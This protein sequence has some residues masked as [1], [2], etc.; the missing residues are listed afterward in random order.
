MI[1]RM[2]KNYELDLNKTLPYFL[3]HIGCGK[4]L[5][6]KITKKVDFAKGSFS[7]ILPCNIESGK[8]FDFSHGGIIRPFPYEEKKY[9]IKDQAEEFHPTQIITM[10][11]ECTAFIT[12]F[13][14]IDC[15]HWVVIENYMLD[16]ESPYVEIKNVRMIPFHSEVY[17]FLNKMNSPEEIYETIRKSGQVWHFLAVLTH[18]KDPVSS[19][20]TDNTMDQICENAAFVIAGAYDGEGYL[21]WKASNFGVKMPLPRWH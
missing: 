13:L 12:D 5:S 10:D 19:I 18:L 15:K 6:E 3:D 20:L 7:T 4:T 8:L 2:V 9:R 1:S 16:P 14:K 11:R 21:F 17:Y